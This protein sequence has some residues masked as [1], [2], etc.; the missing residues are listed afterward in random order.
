M[1]YSSLWKWTF[2][3]LKMHRKP[4]VN[5]SKKQDKIKKTPLVVHRLI[6]IFLSEIKKP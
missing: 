3:D 2:S 6:N 5:T 4:I 1:F